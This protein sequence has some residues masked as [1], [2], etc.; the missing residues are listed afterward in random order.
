MPSAVR[1]LRSHAAAE[2]L[3]RRGD[4]AEDRA[5]RSAYDRRAPT[6]PARRSARSDRSGGQ[7]PR[8]FLDAETTRSGDQRLAPP[9]SMY[10]MN[11]TSALTE[12]PYSIRATS[13]SSL[14][15]RMT[16]VSILS[17]P[18]ARYAA[19]MPAMH[20]VELVEAGQRLEAIGLQRVEADGD[21]PESCG[22]QRVDL[23]G[24]QHAVGGEREIA[25]G[26][27]WRR[28]SAPAPPHPGGAAARRRSGGSCRRRARGR[29]RPARSISSKW[30]TSSRG[31]QT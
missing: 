28:S 22:F 21:A 16:T 15:P 23:I 14:T 11:R 7:A 25:S 13:S 9:T 31:S 24:E 17:W 26:R 6:S 4:D 1:R 27:V 8:A 19:A 29:R 12:R 5:V 3:R 2:R 18:K 20:R 10:S 30:R